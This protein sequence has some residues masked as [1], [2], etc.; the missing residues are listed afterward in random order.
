[1]GLDGAETTA[2]APLGDCVGGCLVTGLTLS[3]SP[4]DATLPWVVT[5]L[6]V[7]GLDALAGAWRP[8]QEQVLQG[9]VP[10]VIVPVADGLMFPA[11]RRTLEATPVAAGPRLP[12]LA[13]DTAEWVDSA[14]LID[15][16]GGDERPA[17]VLGRLPALPLVE[18]D[19]LLADLPRAVAGAPP[20]V[21]AAVVS[22]L[23]RADT[24]GDVLARL[25]DAAGHQP[26]GLDQARADTADDVGAVQ[27]RVYALLAGFCL[28]VALL[29]LVA[30]VA[31]Q[32]QAWIRD[33]A[34]LRVLGVPPAQLRGAGLVEV[35]SLTLAGVTAT[36]LGAVAAVRLLLAHL[37][38]VTVPEHA[39]PLRTSVAVLPVLVAAGAV[40]A[41]VLLV[42]GRGRGIQLAR[43]RP[44]ILREEAAP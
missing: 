17:D 24:P 41:L 39:V 32:R 9:I 4:G 27:A 10:V 42:G 3:G 14:P 13:T 44:A 1:V 5:G 21:P 29:V 30:S 22:V 31:R 35:L 15:S 8:V 38:L 43:S 2:T 19:G 40:A 37:D 25:A 16:P 7:G 36:G 33:V 23:A 11:T 6:D 26:R 12:V 28:L 20:T 34:A 18:A